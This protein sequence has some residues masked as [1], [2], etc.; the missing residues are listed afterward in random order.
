VARQTFRL[1]LGSANFP[2]LSDLYGQSIVFPQQDMHYIRPNAFSG[3]EADTNIGIPQIIFCENV[4]PTTYGF[5]SVAFDVAIQNTNHADFDEAFYLRDAGEARTLFVPGING[6]DCNRYTYDQVANIWSISYKA[7]P[8][9]AKCTV[10]NLK[11]RT[12][13][14]A[15]FDDEF[16]EWTGAWGNVT[17]TGLTPANMQGLVAANA[18]LIAYDYNTVYWS[19]TTDPTDFVPSL[20]SGAGSQRILANKG[21]IVICRPIEDGYIIYTTENVII[22]KY[23][24][25]TRFPWIFREIKN[26]GGTADPE[27]TCP[28]GDESQIYHYST[29]GMALIQA[30][31]AKKDFAAVDE[32]LGCRKIES[33]NAV[34]NNIDITYLTDKPRVKITFIASRW[35]VISYGAV[36]LTHAV[37]YDTVLKRWG[38][39]RIDHVDCFEFSGNPGTVGST[40]SLT[41]AQLPGTWAQQNNTWAEYGSIISGG[42]GSLNVPYRSLAFLRADGQVKVVDFDFNNLNDISY[43]LLGRVQFLRDRLW[44]IQEVWAETV[45]RPLTVP[46]NSFEIWSTYDGRSYAS[47]IIPWREKIKII[48]ANAQG[49]DKIAHW[50]A[51][52]TAKSHSL[53]FKGNFNLDSVAARGI[54]GGKR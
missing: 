12:F 49:A 26:S 4:F 13:V 20:I 18:Y 31:K 28:D 54:L 16:W 1:N 17:L 36:T 40:T 10:A 22:A 41:W 5:Q 38:K 19:S 27:H 46:Q 23:S 47:K 11:S 39:V 53:F 3:A 25:N 48:S 2:F 14:H 15:A 37:V 21:R 29:D 9:G 45:D 35:L 7:V 50:K 44:T 52:K 43:L 42:S 33:F 24:G 51:R 8:S 30:T 32:F 6:I 34:T